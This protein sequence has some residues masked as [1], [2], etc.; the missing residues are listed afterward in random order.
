MATAL[1]A[2]RDRF[3]MLFGRLVDSTTR[4][5]MA[6]PEEQRDSM[7]VRGDAVRFGDRV[8]EVTAKS[9]F[10]HMIVAEHGWARSLRDC[11][12]GDHIPVPRNA[13]LT[14]ALA[15]TDYIGRAQELHEDNM[16]IFAGFPEAA[17]SREIVFNKSR[18]TL[19]GLLWG[20]Y[21]HRAFHL[22]NI[23]IYVRQFGA[24]PADFFNFDAQPMA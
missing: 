19:L 24:T 14:Q 9:L 15:T 5:I 11:N 13:A 16:R 12:E 8:S 17:L 7:P 6:M 10:I 23:D 18:W 21:S 3:L 4:M 22:G 20:V 1:Q 2:E